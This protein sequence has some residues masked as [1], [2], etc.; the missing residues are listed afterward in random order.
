MAV[1][2]FE[3]DRLPVDENLRVADLNLAEADSLG[4]DFEDA[5]TVGECGCEGVEVGRLG[6]PFGRGGD[7]ERPVVCA[8]AFHIGLRDDL[9]IGRMEGEEASPP[10]TMSTSKASV[11]SQ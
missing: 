1:G 10:E 3:E 2:S 11:A 9:A 8:C 7:G 5:T 6:R 4:D